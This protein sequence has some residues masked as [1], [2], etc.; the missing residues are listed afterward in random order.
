MDDAVWTGRGAARTVEDWRE[1]FPQLEVEEPTYSADVAG[2]LK[3]FDERDCVLA[4]RDLP[5]GSE[6]SAVYYAAHPEHRAFD[7]EM[8]S[9]PYLGHTETTA[10]RAMLDALFG[11]VLPLGAP[12][13]VVGQPRGGPGMP[14]DLPPAVAAAKVKGFARLLGADAVGIGPLRQAFVYTNVGRTFYGQ[15]YGEPIA[16]AHPNAISLGIKMNVAGLNRTSPGYPE[17]LESALAYA[18]G[19]LMAVQLAAYIRGLGFAARAH[20]LRNYQ[21]LSVPVAVDGGL[22]ELSRCGIL[23]SREFGNCL[24]LATVTTDLPLALDKPV[25]LG[26]QRF[27]GECVACARACP[28]GA[29]PQGAKTEVRG[30]RKWA[31]DAERCYR[32]WH[33]AGSDCGICISVCPWS[34]WALGPR[35]KEKAP[36]VPGSFYQPD[37][38]PDWLE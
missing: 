28:A 31:L 6:R 24:R 21:V 1:F 29:I 3:R 4:R 12:E 34:R 37:R 36:A 8:R 2:E 26:V 5:P 35:Q 10:N 14:V 7:D 13:V 33:E 15:D 16:L 23:I 19:A 30:A 25:D 32:Y 17:V 11:S 18:R 38:R 20:L 27:C 22:G 9:L